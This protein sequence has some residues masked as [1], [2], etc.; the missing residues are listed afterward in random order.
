MVEDDAELVALIDNELDGKT[1]ADLLR[2]LSVDEALR[3]RHEALR[4][5]GIRIADA[6]GAVVERAP[7]DRLHAAL[8]K[9]EAQDKA[10]RRW[11]ARAIRDLAAAIV[12]ALL[13]A[14]IASW[15]TLRIASNDER[16]DWKAAVVEYMDLYTNDTFALDKPDPLVA[17]EKLHVIGEKLGVSLTPDN[18]A[19]QGLSFKTA[20]ILSYDGAP[21]A[22]I[23]YVDAEDRPVLF[24][25][26]ANGG[27]DAPI[28]SGK[29]GDF[30]LSSWSRAGRGY[31]VIGR[32]PEQQSAELARTLQTRFSGT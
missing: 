1:R 29:R 8:L 20:Q 26:I 9:A 3:D 12:I 10:R 30:S 15:A 13:A 14:G 22:E 16:E 32:F 2:R 31:L 25:I 6:F 4:D 19:V 28:R 23:A 24:C 5:A 17:A 27:A 18:I 7:V 11:G 21:L